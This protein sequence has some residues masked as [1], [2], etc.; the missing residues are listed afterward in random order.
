MT[1]LVKYTVRFVQQNTEVSDEMEV[2]EGT[3]FIN[4][5]KKNIKVNNEN[6]AKEFIRIL[7]HDNEDNIV[8]IP[9][10]VWDSKEGLVDTEL[11]INDVSTI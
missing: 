6:D 10:S 4:E 3:I 9:Q 7:Y 11:I 5:E 2:E 1:Y 8:I